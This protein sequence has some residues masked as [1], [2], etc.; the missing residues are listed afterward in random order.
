M[1]ANDVGC[2][3]RNQY[4]RTSHSLW[5][6]ATTRAG[7]EEGGGGGEVKG[8]TTRDRLFFTKWE[9]VS[10]PAGRILSHEKNALTKIE[11]M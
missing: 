9:E 7:R 1:Q 8:H 6:C 2:T 4:L 11:V 5:A 3:A 10:L